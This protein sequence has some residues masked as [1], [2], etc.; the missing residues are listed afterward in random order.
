MKRFS[1]DVTSVRRARVNV[2]AESD[3]EAYKLA[4]DKCEDELE[5]ADPEIAMVID[6]R[7]ECGP[8]EAIRI[9]H[10]LLDRSRDEVNDYV[11]NRICDAI[12]CLKDGEK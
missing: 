6:K 4:E 10:N 11:Y 3:M 12:I 2:Y 5:F 8:T 9:L 7:Y 1:I